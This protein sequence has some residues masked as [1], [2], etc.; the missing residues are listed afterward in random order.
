MARRLI[1]RMFF[2]M[3]IYPNAMN[4]DPLMSYLIHIRQNTLYFSLVLYHKVCMKPDLRIFVLHLCMITFIKSSHFDVWTLM[5]LFYTTWYLRQ[6]YYKNHVNRSLARLKWLNF[7]YVIKRQ[8]MSYLQIWPLH[9]IA[10][11]KKQKSINICLT[12]SDIRL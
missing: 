2:Q 9:K 11:E 12:V 6:Y 7:S 3:L 1:Y 8:Y 4:N 10:N 5:S